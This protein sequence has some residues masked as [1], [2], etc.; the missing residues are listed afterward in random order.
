MG[1]ASC[2]T[3]RFIVN[4]VSAFFRGTAVLLSSVDSLLKNASASAGAF[5]VLGG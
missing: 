1:V 5:V 3:A 4:V 2:V